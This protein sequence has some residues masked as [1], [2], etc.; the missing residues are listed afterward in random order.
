VIPIVVGVF[1]YYVL[2]PNKTDNDFIYFVLFPVL[3]LFYTIPSLI[4]EHKSLQY[5]NQNGLVEN[6]K[7]VMFDTILGA[8]LLVISINFIITNQSVIVLLILCPYYTIF[9]TKGILYYSIKK[10]D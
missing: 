3:A 2:L 9:I 7:R 5:F 4:V 8:I 10:D 6:E 1:I